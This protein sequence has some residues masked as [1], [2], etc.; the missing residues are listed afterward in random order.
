MHINDSLLNYLEK[1]ILPQYESFDKAH[2]K[3]H[4]IEV[5][6][7]CLSIAESYAVDAELL[8]TAAA[9]HDLGLQEGREAHHI[10]SA[11]IIRNDN[12]LRKWFD[13]GQI[14]TIAQAA[15]DHRASCG[16]KP[17]SIYGR[18]LAEAD[19]LIIPE[20]IIMRTIQYQR[21][22][23]P[24]ATSDEVWKKVRRHLHEKY[25]EGGYLRL[26]IPESPNW[27]G[28]NQLREIIADEKKLKEIFGLLYNQ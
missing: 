1:D 8:V 20:Q 16:H 24:E 5:M 12:N 23:N 19:R 18:I 14:E 6:E 3:N 28:L 17:R 4:A 25:A 22:H 11:R 7:R 26:W 21:S 10:V 27:T 15:E 9:Y 2:R 13:E